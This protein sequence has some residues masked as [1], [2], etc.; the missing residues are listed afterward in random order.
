[1]G[2]PFSAKGSKNEGVKTCIQPARTTRSG[3]C[4]R[5][6]S[7]RAAS[8]RDLASASFPASF[9]PFAWNPPDTILKYSDGMA[10]FSAREMAKAVFRFTKSRTIR[11]SGM[12]PAATASSTA[13]KLL[14][15][16]LAMTTIRHGGA[17]A[18]P[19]WPCAGKRLAKCLGGEREEQ[20]GRRRLRDAVDDDELVGSKPLREPALQRLHWQSC[21][22][23]WPLHSSGPLGHPTNNI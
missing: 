21:K 20:P 11:E 13:W 15:L 19:G 1:M 23:S 17:M 7:A 10:A 6:F 12:R 2:T 16:P 4:C 3:L 22:K 14:P 8:Y 5:T 18:M 9:S